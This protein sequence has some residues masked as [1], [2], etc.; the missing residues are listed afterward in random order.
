[1][2]GRFLTGVTL[3]GTANNRMRPRPEVPTRLLLA[4]PHCDKYEH[5]TVEESLRGVVVSTGAS[6]L[7]LARKILSR[8]PALPVASAGQVGPMAGAE[9][10]CRCFSRRVEIPLEGEIRG[11]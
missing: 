7:S 6:R 2:R 4:G 3:K 9:L 10:S 8:A 11:W 5:A 1:M